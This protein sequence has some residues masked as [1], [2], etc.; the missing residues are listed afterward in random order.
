MKNLSVKSKFTIL[1]LVVI[2]VATVAVAIV[3]IN[4]FHGYQEEELTSR[5]HG[6]AYMTAGIFETARAYTARLTEAAASAPVQQENLS[7]LLSAMNHNHDG[8]PIYANMLVF[9][10]YLNL[11]LAANPD[12]PQTDISLAVF[13]PNVSA[14]RAGRPHMSYAVRHPET[15]L[16]QFLFT[17][18]IIID[19][20]FSG[21]VAVPVNTQGLGFFLES[22]KAED[23]AASFITIAD[24][25]GTIFFSNVPAYV[26][27][28]AF[29]LEAPFIQ[30]TLFYHTSP[31][32]G[33]DAAVYITTNTALGWTTISFI[34]ANTIP[35]ITAEII[36]SLVPTVGGITLAAALMVFVL[37]RSLKPLKA[38]AAAAI[39]VAAGRAQVNLRVV[40]N[41]E[42]GKVSN[43]FLK[44]IETLNSVSQEFSVM[45]DNI[46]H[47][48]THYRIDIENGKLQGIFREIAEQMN[49][50][51]HDFEFTID[52]MSEPYILISHD[53][54]VMH[55]NQSIRKL[56]GTE[57]M[58]WDEIVGMHV[59]DYLNSEISKHP[60][61]IKAFAEQAPQLKIDIQLELRP[62]QFYDF[63]Y[64]CIPYYYTEEASGAVLML[65]NITHI[66]DM[67]RRDMQRNIYQH[68]RT[69]K[70]TQTIV[71]AFENGNLAITI[72][73]SAFD[74]ETADIAQEQDA[75]EAVVKKSMNIIKGYVDEITA[76]LH[77]ISE[78]NFDVSIDRE[79]IGDFGS[80]KDSLG[81]ITESVSALISEIQAA[82]AG[83]EDGA[84]LISQST[85]ALMS[86]FEEQN[87]A[88]SEV[89]EA[90]G[91]LTQKTH[92]SAQD[93]L[94]ARNLTENVRE[95]AY[96]GT[97]HMQDL[98]AAMKE[99]KQSSE[100][101]AKVTSIIESIAFQTN[102][103]ALNA[104]VEA[105]RAGDAG[106][107]FA[108]VAEE[109]RNLAKRSDASAKDTSAMLAKSM[110]LV[111]EGVAKS[112]QTAEALT[113]IAETATSVTDV[114]S[115]MAK[116]SGQQADEISKIQNSIEAI[117]RG[118]SDNANS[119]QS[120]ASV[121]EELS[122]QASVLR[123]L[124]EQFII[125]RR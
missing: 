32:S 17:H 110:G 44:I 108:V 94:S 14:A 111:E 70:V 114:V 96:E 106:R 119:V 52:L 59:D 61:T 58:T 20:I 73:Q 43:A 124:T 35:N 6:N 49:N 105:A 69:E 81:L 36:I 46:Q 47:G 66:R 86:N 67:Q 71:E 82:S 92:K 95:A 125:K 28:N 1:L 18:P 54:R 30:N 116:L 9:D 4:Q 80:I 56:T 12:G 65:A 40:N 78:N 10:P 13:E 29:E 118:S 53:M 2:T 19:G 99:I 103:L 60:A 109:V 93:A 55:V 5:L 100:E 121:S 8:V 74:E 79:F 11:I 25:N 26:G 48:K 7:A 102:L 98:S 76:I 33:I 88:M 42:I 57:G 122:S 62:G 87:A 21:L 112:L 120:N 90:I 22:I 123:A 23:A 84:N 83:V 16:I 115:D 64:N 41:D 89:T 45:S 51:V 63:E 15:G 85:Q 113:N 34:D 104:S 24:R 72:P 101:I 3:R 107:G 77:E 39:D 50:V 68:S 91:I 27:R 31:V 75:V 117:Y 38:L 37:H 97:Q